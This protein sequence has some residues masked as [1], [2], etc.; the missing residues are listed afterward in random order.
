MT[1]N[2]AT[3][4]NRKKQKI[5]IKIRETFV[6]QASFISNFR[7]G[8]IENV[9]ERVILKNLTIKSHKQSS[10]LTEF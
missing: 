5:S 6:A 2:N 7:L 1:F 10:N 8:K 9:I 3:I 4:K